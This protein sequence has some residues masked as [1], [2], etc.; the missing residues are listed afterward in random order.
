[1]CELSGYQNLGD[2]DEIRESI[3]DYRKLNGEFIGEATGTMEASSFFGATLITPSVN[4]AQIPKPSSISEIDFLK[5]RQI[6][7]AVLLNI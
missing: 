4:T 6:I 2:N 5:M 7:F 3:P 1:V